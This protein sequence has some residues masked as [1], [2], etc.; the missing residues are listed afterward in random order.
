MPRSV[1][2]YSG[3]RIGPAHF[4]AALRHGQTVGRYLK[5]KY[6][7]S[8]SSGSS[9]SRKKPKKAAAFRR[10]KTINTMQSNQRSVRKTTG[11][12]QVRSIQHSKKAVKVTPRFRKKV[13]KVIA[14]TL[15]HGTYFSTRQGTIGFNTTNSATSSEFRV[16]AQ[17]GYT[18]N[19]ISTKLNDECSANSRIWFGGAQTG[20]DS[21]TTG[22]EWQFF[23]PLKLI[24]AAS[25][26][27]NQKTANRDYTVQ[28]G[29]LTTTHNGTT[30]SLV[31][32]TAA[33]PEIDGLKI[34]VRNAY[35]KM[36]M[37]NNSQR[38]LL[39]EVYK[40][41][42]TSKNP[43]ALALSTFADAIDREV[44][45]TNTGL[46][47]VVGVGSEV[48]KSALM[49]MPGVEPNQ[50]VSFRNEWKYEK[51]KI[52]IMPGETTSLF[53][54][55]PK[56]YM[57]DYDKL[58]KG[59]ANV[60]GL[61]LKQTTMNVMMSVTPDLTFATAA[62]IGET[63]RWI[64]N[65]ALVGLIG[66]MISLEWSEVYSLIMPDIVGFQNGPAADAGNM[67]TLNKRLN[68]RAYANFVSQHDGTTDPTYEAY[69]VENPGDIIAAGRPN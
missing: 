5:R 1:T 22:D 56:D 40:C 26:L 6:Q 35:V 39:V 46:C 48:P 31:N 13:K 12:N 9:Q 17:G 53:F 44:D 3:S 62:P 36:T 4:A 63:G 59:N 43:L 11:R 68:R 2:R 47:S 38:A 64:Q 66:D 14:G 29:N 52:K 41:V 10:P 30:G 24:D 51:V 58:N 67:Y 69:D 18:N 42:P 16:A 33:A 32:G 7:S 54:Q 27:W 50:F 57:L 8:S 49:N 20:N 45:G 15:H 19:V 60:Q 65:Q 21:F 37:K 23:S 61:A 25:V 55:G 34:Q 28:T